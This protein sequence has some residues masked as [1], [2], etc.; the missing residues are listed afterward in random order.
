M[1]P[2][3]GIRPV[4]VNKS[5]NFVIV[6]RGV[7]PRRAIIEGMNRCSERCAKQHEQPRQINPQDENRNNR[8]RTVNL[9][10]ARSIRDISGEAALGYLK[11]QRCHESPDRPFAQAPAAIPNQPVS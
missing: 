5:Y 10:V 8:E 7:L 11:Q 2:C 6:L 1:T 3:A 9:A 4:W